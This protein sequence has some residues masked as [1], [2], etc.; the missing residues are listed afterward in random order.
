MVVVMVVVVVVVLVVVD[1]FFS[2]FVPFLDC[3]FIS[4]AP[5]G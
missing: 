3:P 1:T 2:I 4:V 5:Y